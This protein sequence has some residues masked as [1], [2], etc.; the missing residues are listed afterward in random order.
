MFVCI[1]FFFIVCSSYYCRP[2][3]I[4]RQN[5][6]NMLAWQWPNKQT[7]STLGQRS[8]H[9]KYSVGPSG[10]RETDRDRDRERDRGREYF[11]LKWLQVK[12]LYVWIWDLSL[13]SEDRNSN[14]VTLLKLPGH[15][16][17]GCTTAAPWPELCKVSIYV[18]W[19]YFNK[20]H[21]IVTTL[22]HGSHGIKQMLISLVQLWS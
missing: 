19:Q 15:Q 9:S 18:G 21:E 14:T 6:T 22:F 1:G 16:S 17:N 4:S 10:K 7:L 2:W 8:G 11:H 12:K 5:T 3:K 20:Q 13:Q